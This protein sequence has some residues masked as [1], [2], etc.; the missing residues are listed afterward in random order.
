MTNYR[1]PGDVSAFEHCLSKAANIAVTVLW[2]VVLS[3]RKMTMERVR[4]STDW[5]PHKFLCFLPVLPCGRE[6]NTQSKTRVLIT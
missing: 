5:S 2:A 3:E 4:H 1:M 6:M